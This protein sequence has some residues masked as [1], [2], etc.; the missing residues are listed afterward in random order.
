MKEIRNR[1][2]ILNSEDLN[3]FFRKTAVNIASYTKKPGHLS[4]TKKLCFG[5]VC[6]KDAL[7]SHESLTSNFRRDSDGA[8]HPKLV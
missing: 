3:F 7:G 4:K 5:V 1:T 2:V 8:K 6:S